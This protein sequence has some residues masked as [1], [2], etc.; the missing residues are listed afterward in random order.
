MVNS[1]SPVKASEL[2]RILKQDGWY[3]IRQEGS[4]ILMRHAIKPG[5]LSIPYHGAKEVGKGLLK[6]TLKKAKLNL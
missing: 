4:H 1:S 6:D 3:I 2:M 5:L